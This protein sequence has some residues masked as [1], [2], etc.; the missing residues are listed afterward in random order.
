MNK[1]INWLV[2]VPNRSFDRIPEPSRFLT[3]FL[4]VMV[5]VIACSTIPN[6]SMRDFT[7]ATLCISLTLWRVLYFIFR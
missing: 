1:L 4:S 6:Q 2:I 5:V 3:F 7:T